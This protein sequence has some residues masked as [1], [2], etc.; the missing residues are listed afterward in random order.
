MRKGWCAGQ[1]HHTPRLGSDKHAWLR[2]FTCPPAKKRKVRTESGGLRMERYSAESPRGGWEQGHWGPALSYARVRLYPC[3]HW[4][5]RAISERALAKLL[6]CLLVAKSDKSARSNVFQIQRCVKQAAT[7]L[8]A[9]TET[10]TQVWRCFYKFIYCLFDTATVNWKK[11][12][13]ELLQ[14]IC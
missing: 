14:D 9:T 3:S 7:R 8:P 2:V 10:S 13:N 6:M 11:N 12:L 1:G 5:L 4:L